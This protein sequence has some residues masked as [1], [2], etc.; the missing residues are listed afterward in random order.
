[1]SY[2]SEVLA[3]GPALYWRLDE[4]SGT[5][6][7]D[8]SGHSRGGVMAGSGTFGSPSLLPGDPSGK[9]FKANSSHITAD[10]YSP[11]AAATRTLEAWINL[12]AAGSYDQILGGETAGGC[13]TL[14]SFPGS[15]T[16]LRWWNGTGTVAW[17][18]VITRGAAHH[19]ALIYNDVTRVAELYVDG[20]S[21]GTQTLPGVYP[22]GYIGQKLRVCYSGV[23]G[24]YFMAGFMDE[25]AVYE[26]ALSAARIQAHYTAGTSTGPAPVD[27]SP[28]GFV[29]SETVDLRE[30]SGNE[31]GS[32]TAL[33]KPPKASVA[34][35]N[36]TATFT[37]PGKPCYATGRSSGRQS[38]SLENVARPR[39][40]RRESR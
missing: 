29:G 34:A 32:E 17:N 14:D 11:Y 39:K 22:A 7:A 28:S 21:C 24:S 3:D 31:V 9:S 19:I 35:V 6:V 33:L 15:P 1:M 4:A 16:V 2:Q 8:A 10:A 23:G 38:F 30:V 12:D 20:S 18:N 25:F 26:A 40:K 37:T 13:P 27:W 36:G 5:T